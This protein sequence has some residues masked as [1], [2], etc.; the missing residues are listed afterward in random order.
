MYINVPGLHVQLIAN[1]LADG[2]DDPIPH[3]MPTDEPAGQY[4]PLTHVTRDVPPIFIIISFHV[5]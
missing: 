1:V 5:R 4:V 2:D 3:E